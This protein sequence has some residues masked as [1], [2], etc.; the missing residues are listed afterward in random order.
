MFINHSPVMAEV[1]IKD[2][3]FVPFLSAEEIQVRVQSLATKIN[4]DYAG[5]KPLMIVVLNGAFIFAADLIRHLDIQPE[6]QFIRISTYGDA[7]SSSETAQLML[8]LEVDVEGREVILVEDII[9]SGFT[10][11]YFI[12]HVLDQEPDSIKIATLLYKS[13]LFKGKYVP[14]YIGFDIPEAFVI[15]YGLDYAQRGRE[16]PGI[17]QLAPG[18]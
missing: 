18:T 9:E 1:T 8:G 10:A 5:K 13:S 4:Q 11:A 17:Y 7:M 6:V 2:K 3:K 15:G 14:D 12:D 16:L